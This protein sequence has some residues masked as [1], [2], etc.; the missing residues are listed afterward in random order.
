[1]ADV[2]DVAEAVLRRCGPMDTFR[3][4]K[5]VYYAQACHLARHP[6]PLFGSPIKAWANGPVVPS[7]YHAHKGAFSV[8]SVGGNPLRLSEAEQESVALALRLYGGHDSTW[9]V[10]QTHSEP[11]WVEARKGVPPGANAS[12][13]IDTES[14]RAYYST[15]LNDPE[16][17]ALLGEVESDGLT[18]DEV[19]KRYSA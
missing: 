1:M 5:L 11:P 14:M 13:G 15:I 8:A 2:F 19:R 3:L 7:L 6:T 18:A 17:D 9:L 16:I 10:N 12:P 4:Q